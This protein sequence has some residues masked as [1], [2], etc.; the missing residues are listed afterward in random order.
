MKKLML[1]LSFLALALPLAAQTAR[2]EIAA[3]PAKAAGLHYAYPGPQ[4][5]QT[6]APKGFKPFY[7]SHFGRHG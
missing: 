6:P 4:S 3:D 2:D 7:I 5:V 1:L